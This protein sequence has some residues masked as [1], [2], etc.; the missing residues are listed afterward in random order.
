MCLYVCIY[1]DCFLSLPYMS[2]KN[3]LLHFLLPMFD[4]R[5]QNRCEAQMSDS[6]M[7]ALLVYMYVRLHTAQGC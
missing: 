6:N 1:I 2:N 7:L 5:L 3:T 4:P